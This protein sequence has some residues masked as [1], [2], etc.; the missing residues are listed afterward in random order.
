MS[1]EGPYSPHTPPEPHT[2]FHLPPPEPD[3]IFDIIGTLRINGIYN[4]HFPNE[5]TPKHVKLTAVNWPGAS[6]TDNNK[7]TAY[8]ARNVTGK[9]APHDAAA[10]VFQKVDGSI[11]PEEIRL[12]VYH[13]LDSN[14]VSIQKHVMGYRGDR[15]GTMTLTLSD[16]VKS[17]GIKIAEVEPPRPMASGYGGR[18]RRNTRKRRSK[19]SKKTRKHVRR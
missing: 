2:P 14:G 15:T 3:E 9:N 16:A 11:N 8:P 18:R 13:F 10:L 1:E 17:R 5:E 12:D 6:T 19:R 4:I 7:W